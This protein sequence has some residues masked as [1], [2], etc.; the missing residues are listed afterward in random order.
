MLSKAIKDLSTKLNEIVLLIFICFLFFFIFLRVFLI[1]KSGEI[2]YG[3]T[4][5]VYSSLF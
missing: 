5:L 1:L 2:A 3:K 4:V